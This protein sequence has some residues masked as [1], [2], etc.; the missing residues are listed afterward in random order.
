MSKLS[1]FLILAGG[2]AALAFTPARA[3]D[4]TG[5]NL[6]W[7]DEFDQAN[8]TSPSS[9]KWN[10]D[11]GGN[12]WGN[13]ELQYYTSRTA[14]ARI[15][16]GQLVIEAKEEDFG[17]R[18][19][20]SARL[21]TKGKSS[22]TYGRMEARMKLPRGQGIWPAFWMLGAN[23]DSAPWPQC[24]EIDIMEN[25]GKEPSIV[26]G[27]IHGPGYSGGNPVSGDYTLSGAVLADDFH[28]FTV[29]WDQD[30]IRWFLDG[31]QY[32][33]VTP[34]SLPAGTAWVFN[35]PQFILLNL[36]VGGNWPGNPNG[37]TVFP[38]RLTV[39]YVRVYSRE[40]QNGANVLANP[41]FEAG[42]LAN[43]TTFGANIS[44][45]TDT[46]CS[47][48]KSS[49]VYGQFSGGQNDSGLSQD[50]PALP[51]DSFQADSWLLTPKNDSI[52]G[53]NTAWAEVSFHD[54]GGQV[55]SLYRSNSLGAGIRG[56]IWH[57]L[58]VNR[59]L[60]PVDGSFLGLVTDLVAPEGTVFARKRVVFRQIA[61]AGGS[62]RFDDLE[63]F[64][65]AG[66]VPPIPA[67]VTIDPNATWRGFM[68]VYHLPA[69]GGGLAFAEGW[70][71]ADLRATFAGGTL[72][73]AP[74]TINNPAPYWYIGGGGPDK[75]GN[76]IMGAN[77][78]VEENGGLSGKTVTFTGKVLANTLTA[79][80]TSIA[81]IKDFAPDY[82]SANTVTTSLVPGTFTLSLATDPAPGRHVQ[83]GFLTT[84]P[85]VWPTDAG[86]Y[87]SVQA[88]AVLP[89]PFVTWMNDFDFS[90]FTTP[91]LTRTGDPDG[92]GQNNLV[93]YA[94]DGDPSSPAASGKTRSSITGNGG[95]RVLLLTLPVLGNPV[96]TGSPG[97]GAVSGSLIYSIEGS[98]DLVLFDQEVTE[99]ATFAEDMPTLTPGWTYRTFRLAG[100]VDGEASRGP[101]GYLRARI[102]GTP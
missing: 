1:R 75:A 90:T 61:N 97:K 20:T 4:P 86:D 45:A 18:D 35:Q 6:V 5:W 10:F 72:T 15:E 2:L 92:D 66:I 44:L 9:A 80:H 16:G 65:V 47:G 39:D 78:Y 17:G 22:W 57:P 88:T 42:G 21:I 7:S 59:Q 62:V 77:M 43:W 49:K 40:P 53:A 12:G 100:T 76:K 31:C 71:V 68:N 29:E 14:N 48:T 69:N 74:N 51:G 38:Q 93:E 60:N 63:L 25:I 32:F 95:D 24:G 64:K 11:T 94:L 73:L 98:N 56:G 89:D 81:F 46:A 67:N 58:P 30:R 84:G 8:G 19:Y 99:V 3:Q 101:V 26:H 82:S 37:S 83:Y 27:T 85:C 70:G 23:I 13:N 50:V 55:L 91:D 96:F 52:A 28:V 34:S 41:G 54:A 87:G 79:S 36:A 33:T 102:S